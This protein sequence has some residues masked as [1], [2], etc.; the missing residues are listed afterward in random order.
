MFHVLG[1]SQ[2]V[3]THLDPS[4]ADESLRDLLYSE[5]KE[6]CDGEPDCTVK[7]N[8]HEHSASRQLVSR[9]H[10]NTDGEEDDDLA[11]HKKRCHIQAPQIRA[12]HDL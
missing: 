9:Q 11:G 4:D 10:V 7:G 5:G 1:V 8:G 2:C 6:E 3:F 12:L